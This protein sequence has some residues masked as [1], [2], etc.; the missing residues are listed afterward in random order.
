MFYSPVYYFTVLLTTNVHCLEFFLPK[1]SIHFSIQ[2]SKNLA[3]IPKDLAMNM[4]K[5][6]YDILLHCSMPGLGDL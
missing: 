3:S 2:T 6:P 4:L 5:T 1:W